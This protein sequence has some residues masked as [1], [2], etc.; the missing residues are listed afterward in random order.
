MYIRL[1]ATR[2][3]FV[4]KDF[5]IKIPN[6]Q[7][8]RLFLHGILSNLK[9]KS[10]YK[11]CKNRDDLAKV[12]FCDKLGLILIMERA[13][14]LNKNINWLN[15]KEKIYE[16]YENDN[17]KDIMIS[18]CKPTNWGYINNKLIKIDYGS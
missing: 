4:F 1:G 5:V 16:K 18:D 12:K 6:I 3:V 14:E 13:E 2:R 10:I 9:E 7:E 8:Y 11:N 17:M 15:F